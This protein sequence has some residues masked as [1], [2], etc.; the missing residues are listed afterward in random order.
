VDRHLC[1]RWF[2]LQPAAHLRSV[3][4]STVVARFLVLAVGAAR[5]KHFQA[6]R[7]EVSFIKSAEVYLQVSRSCF[8]IEWVRDWT[9]WHLYRA[10]F[11]LYLERTEELPQNKN[12]LFCCYPHGVLCSGLFGNF[13][14]KSPEFDKLFP[15]LTSTVHTLDGNFSH[16]FVRDLI[17]SLGNIIF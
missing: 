15:G 9:W 11:P 7:S 10:Y 17:L 4:H 13:A 3:L 5:Q 8:R 6:R 16:P 12:Y 2:F 14:T 1:V